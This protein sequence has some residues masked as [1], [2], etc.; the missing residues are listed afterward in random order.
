MGEYWCD[1]EGFKGLYQ[2]SDLG[3]VKS[4]DRVIIDKNGI[5]YRNKSQIL[6]PWNDGNGYMIVDLRKE[7]LRK[8]AKVHRL[9][10]EAFIPNTLE[11]PQVNHIDG[12]KENNC[13]TN[14]EWCTSSENIKHAFKTGLM[15][16]RENSGRKKEPVLQ[17]KNGKVINQFSTLSEAERVTK[18]SR[19]N[20]R[21]VLN[22][23]RK[24]AN[25]CQWERVID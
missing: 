18:T 3:R 19:Q 9:V 16:V 11:K 15:K 8:T 1:I 2:V 24:S 14:L 20:I 22:G 23:K 25:K 10:A 5:S 13:L 7:G 21:S 17:I 4:L 6:K 12:N